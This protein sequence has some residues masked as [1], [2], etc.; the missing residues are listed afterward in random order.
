M[1]INIKITSAEDALQAQKV[2]AALAGSGGLSETTPKT[3]E[4]K[5]TAPKKTTTKKAKAAD[6]EKAESAEQ[7]ES[8][9]ELSDLYKELQEVIGQ[10]PNGKNNKKLKQFIVREF[11]LPNVGRLEEAHYSKVIEYA[12]T[13]LKDAEPK[14]QQQQEAVEAISESTER[15]VTR[16]EL[17]KT[18]YNLVNA[19]KRE[20]LRKTL[21][22]LGAAKISSLDE[23]DYVKAM[24]ALEAL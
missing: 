4:P 2:F 6:A 8:T 15:K 18:V 1:E 12:N 19:G 10:L 23:S 21:D 14:Q 3:V 9:E 13:L 5:A 20:E 17:E 11:N 22:E 16:A 7:V 24:E